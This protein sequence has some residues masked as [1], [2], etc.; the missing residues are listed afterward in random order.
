MGMRQGVLLGREQV[1]LLLSSVVSLVLLKALRG[2]LS[3]MGWGMREMGV[4]SKEMTMNSMQ[5]AFRGQMLPWKAT[6]VKA[7]RKKVREV[8]RSLESMQWARMSIFMNALKAMALKVM[9]LR[10]MVMSMMKDLLK[11]KRKNRR[12][13]KAHHV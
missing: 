7:V 6:A 9:A 8:K 13:T 12:R 2:T 1:I 5:I 4:T 10:R 11:M 3:V